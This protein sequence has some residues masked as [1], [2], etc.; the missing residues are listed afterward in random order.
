MYSNVNLF[1]FLLRENTRPN[2][3]NRKAGIQGL[4][5]NNGAVMYQAFQRPI[6]KS[7]N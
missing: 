6:V 7:T 4:I 2:D 5:P 3:I 1:I